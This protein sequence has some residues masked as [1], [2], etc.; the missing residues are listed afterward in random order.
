MIQWEMTGGSEQEWT[1]E[2]GPHGGVRIRNA[3]SGKL[4]AN[5]EG[6]RNNGTTMVQW[7]DDGGPEQEWGFDPPL[8]LGR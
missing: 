7:Q 3:A 5:P 2:P 1:L 8:Q 6:S 4:L